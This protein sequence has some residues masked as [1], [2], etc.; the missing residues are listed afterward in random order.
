MK[1]IKM[2]PI[3]I[4]FTLLTVLLSLGAFGQE[5]TYHSFAYLV[6]EDNSLVL[7]DIVEVEFRESKNFSL[8]AQELSFKTKNSQKFLRHVSIAYPEFPS[9]ADSR[10]NAI[11]LSPSV[12]EATSAWNEK[13][14]LSENN[15]LYIEDYEFEILDDN[16][17]RDRDSLY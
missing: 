7:T 1:L 16:K 4:L 5:K 6:G 15:V 12:E 13:K 11:F 9:T 2:N 10:A 14:S 17:K 8:E 3:K